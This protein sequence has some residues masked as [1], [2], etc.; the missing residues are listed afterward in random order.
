M[1]LHIWYGLPQSMGKH[2]MCR[3]AR[4]LGSRATGPLMLLHTHNLHLPWVHALGSTSKGHANA[5]VGG[6]RGEAPPEVFPVHSQ[7][8]K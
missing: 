4:A 3:I 8:F 1:K 7:Q 6:G 5:E 2:G